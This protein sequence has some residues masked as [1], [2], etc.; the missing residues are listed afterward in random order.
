MGCK[1]RSKCS[2]IFPL[3]LL[4]NYVTYSRT[5]SLCPIDYCPPPPT[6]PGSVTPPPRR[7]VVIHY[8]NH[9]RNNIINNVK[10]VNDTII[11]LIIVGRTSGWLARSQYTLSC[12]GRC[13]FGPFSLRLF[14][15][16]LSFASPAPPQ[17]VC[18]SPSCVCCSTKTNTR[19]INNNQPPEDK[20]A[21][22]TT[23]VITRRLHQF[24]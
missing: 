1:E 4:W 24:R 6:T 9:P 2:I 3:A 7:S 8:H 13:H 10:V 16:P 21:D 19:N 18:G 15:S 11:L 17:P 22:T 23:P 5:I 14:T 20:L 12:P